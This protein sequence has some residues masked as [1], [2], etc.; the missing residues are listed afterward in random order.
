MS[1]NVLFWVGIKSENPHLREKHGDF[2]YLDISKPCW[3]LGVRK[4]ML[5]SFPTRKQLNPIL[6]NIK[7]LGKGGLMFLNK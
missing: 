7:Q 2:K 4:M 5:S 1:K 3:S 6:T